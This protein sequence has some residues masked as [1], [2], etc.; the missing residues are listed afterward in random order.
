MLLSQKDLD[1]L[2]AGFANRLGDITIAPQPV[3]ISDG[4]ILV[5]GD[6]EQ[7][8]T[9]DALVSARLDDIKDALNAYIFG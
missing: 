9:F 4:F 1:R 5:Y 7:N 6:V 8:C 3:N 2:P